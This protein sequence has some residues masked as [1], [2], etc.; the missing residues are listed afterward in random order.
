[1]LNA[2]L[3]TE[4]TIQPAALIVFADKVAQH[5]LVLSDSRTR[6]LAIQ[7]VRASSGQLLPQVG[8]PTQDAKGHTT[9]KIHLAVAD[10]YPDGRHEEILNVSTDDP[11]YR[12]LRIPVTILKRAP[13]RFAAT[14]SDVVLVGA[15]GQPFPS[16]LILIRDEQGQRVHIDQV[17]SDDPAITAQW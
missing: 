2:R 3:V 9:W 1:Q 11:R 10:D 4:V 16:R 5:E 15:A 8:E 7:D 12:D 14:P 17:L 13:Q 6:P